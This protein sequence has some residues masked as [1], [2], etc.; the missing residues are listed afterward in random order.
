AVGSRFEGPVVMERLSVGQ[1]LFLSDEA[2][3]GGDVSLRGASVGG[4][5]AVAGSR[6]KGAA[7]MEGLVIGEDMFLNMNASFSGRVD[8]SFAD[9]AG[10][11]SLR[12]QLEK[13]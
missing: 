12:A 9:I 8:L 6:F 11:L 10:A 7:N 3:F 5:F 13:S 4:Q 1:D 2:Y